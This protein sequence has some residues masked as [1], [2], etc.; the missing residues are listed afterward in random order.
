MKLH[1]HRGLKL[2]KMAFWEKKL[3]FEVYAPK[4]GQNGPQMRLFKLGENFNP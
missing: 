3:C 1:Q 2:N 4:G